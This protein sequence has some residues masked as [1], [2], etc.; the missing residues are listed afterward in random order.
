MRLLFLACTVALVGLCVCSVGRPMSAGAFSSQFKTPTYFGRETTDYCSDVSLL[1][2]G[3][4]AVSDG[5]SDAIRSYYENFNTKI[6]RI[7]THAHT[8]TTHT[9]AHTHTHTHTHTH[10]LNT[11]QQIHKEAT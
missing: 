11:I 9:C 10:K 2:L 7:P 6:S 4:K 1:S 8:Y 3:I 5:T